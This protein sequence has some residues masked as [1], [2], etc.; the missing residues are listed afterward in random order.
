M[1]P[2]KRIGKA[3]IV[4]M[5]DDGEAVDVERRIILPPT[6]EMIVAAHRMIE[7]H[8]EA[9]LGTTDDDP[10][11]DEIVQGTQGKGPR[12]LDIDETMATIHRHHHLQ[13]LDAHQRQGHLVAIPTKVGITG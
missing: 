6:E 11:G 4:E 5:L 10:V 12:D 13:T 9:V 3:D 7:D 1:T 2:A 8:P